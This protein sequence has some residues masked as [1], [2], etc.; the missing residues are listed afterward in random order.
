M[1]TVDRKTTALMPATRH[2]PEPSHR[3]ASDHRSL[4]RAVEAA[5]GAID[6]NML[7]SV[8]PAD[9]GHALQPRRLLAA[10]LR[11]LNEQKVAQGLLTHVNEARL[12]EEASR[13]IIMA[14]FT[15]SMSMDKDQTS[16][17]PMDLCYLFANGGGQA[18]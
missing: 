15:D 13:R 18:H 3:G 17:V 10:G 8:A 5:A 16:D 4:A 7:M 12:A 14:M 2:S 6:H 1:T 9:A 11:F